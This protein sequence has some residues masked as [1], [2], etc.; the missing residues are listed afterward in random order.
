MLETNSP[1]R[2]NQRASGVAAENIETL[3]LADCYPDDTYPTHPFGESAYIEDRRPELYSQLNK[4]KTTKANGDT[5]TYPKDPDQYYH[6][7]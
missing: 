1:L 6:D 5:F 3:L 2:S 7:K 4:M